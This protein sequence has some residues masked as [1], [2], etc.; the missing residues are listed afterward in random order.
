MDED[1]LEM[2]LSRIKDPNLKFSLG[3][4]IGLHHAGLVESDRKVVEE[5]F[6]NRKIQVLVATSTLAWGVNTPTHLVVIKGT[7]FFDARTHRYVDMPITDVLQMMGRAG[8][9]QYDNSGIAVIFVQDE[10]KNFYKKFLYEPFPVESSLHM[11]LHNHMNAEIAG[12]TI[13]FKQDAV[14]YLSWTYYFRRL[15]VNPS[16]YNVAELTPEGINAHLSLLIESTLRDLQS[17]GCVEIDKD[18]FSI[19]TTTLGLVAS[20]YYLTHST[21]GLFH[22]SLE[23]AMT[24]RAVHELMCS[25]NEY[26]ELPVR[27]NEDSLN[28]ELSEQLPWKVDL[29][30]CGSPHVKTNLLLQAHFARAALPISDYYTDLKSVLDQ[31]VRI[32]QAMVDIS[33]EKGLLST[34][35]QCMTL[36]QS[37]KQARWPDDNPLTI[38]PGLEPTTNGLADLPV[39]IYCV[40]VTIF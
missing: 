31:A 29:Y 36:V 2:T 3:F 1:A 40:L 21:V 33:A 9:P 25:A 13:K 8:R 12:G 22:K 14:D 35:L 23:R 39:R 18:E 34:C 11:F 17:S 15:M 37:L 32:F 20:Y 6:V 26:D 5:L 4:G 28:A 24:I 7:E 38:L 30:D 16:Y 10:K 27:H 19:H